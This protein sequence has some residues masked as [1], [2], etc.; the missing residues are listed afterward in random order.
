L[1]RV[2][3]KIDFS[4][5][6]CDQYFN[7][8]S[9]RVFNVSVEGILVSNNLDLIRDAP[10]KNVPFIVT[11]NPFVVTDGFITIDF[12][13]GISDPS[14]NGIEVMYVTTTAPIVSPT[15]APTKAPLSIPVPV[16]TAPISAP[17]PM[18]NGN[19]VYR[20]NCGSS[21]QVIVPPNNIVWSPD[22]YVISGLPQN[23]CGSN[24]T[25]SIYCSSRYFRA[26]NGQPFRYD[27]PVP[28]SNRTYELRLH[29]A[30]QVRRIINSS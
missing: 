27:L 22:Q 20:I 15:K 18:S 16:L 7:K 10:G 9:Q 30:E 8:V 28:V 11:V 1:F 2:V 4:F 23:T 25:N 3:S 12:T 17:I 5:V 19:I 29:F 26:V 24:I 13:A 6:S 14:I 21:N